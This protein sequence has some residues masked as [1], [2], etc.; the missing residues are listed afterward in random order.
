MEPVE[1]VARPKFYMTVTA[2]DSLGNPIPNQSTRYPNRG[3]TTGGGNGANAGV[4]E[5]VVRLFDGPNR[6]EICTEDDWQ[7]PAC[8]VTTV[9]R[10]LPAITI[11]NPVADSFVATERNGLGIIR[12]P[13]TGS[14]SRGVTTVYGFVSREAPAALTCEAAAGLEPQPANGSLRRVESR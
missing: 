9:T 5:Q 12:I 2:V 8:E 4:I 11:E 14:V 1:K 13:V 3:R 7:N 6:I 10:L